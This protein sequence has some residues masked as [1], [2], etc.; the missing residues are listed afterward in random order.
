M[1]FVP[2]L[3]RQLL[4][5]RKP[6]WTP[7]ISLLH[8]VSNTSYKRDVR[9]LIGQSGRCFVRKMRNLSPDSSSIISST[10]GALYSKSLQITVL[11]SS[12]QWSISKSII[13]SSTFAYLVTILEQTVLWS[14]RTSTFVK[15]SSRPEIG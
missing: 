9:S 12:K 6:I 8:L 4:S 15:H 2:L 1:A 10:D 11:L 3:R 7:C 14:E 5:F 13:T